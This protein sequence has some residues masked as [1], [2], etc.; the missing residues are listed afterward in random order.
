VRLIVDTSALL[1]IRHAEPERQAFHRWLIEGR[2]HMS[3]ASLAELT[4]VWQ[5]RHGAGSLS[6]LDDM[7][8]GY[9][10]AI[11]PV[12]AEDGPFLRQGIERF[13]KGRAA[14]PACLNFG[15]LFAY[16]LARRL[17]LPLLYKGLDFGRTDVLAVSR[18]AGEAAS[19]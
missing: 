14:D 19:P 11:E 10:I 13:A 9:A 2:A 16:A 15:D 17:D 1:A 8:A 4:L 7:I 5:A 18:P 12:T 6:D 3:I